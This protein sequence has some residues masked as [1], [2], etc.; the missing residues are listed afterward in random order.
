MIEQGSELLES[1]FWFPNRPGGY[2]S[3]GEGHVVL[4][5]LGSLVPRTTSIPIRRPNELFY[6]AGE[7]ERHAR[8]YLCKYTSC[9]RDNCCKTKTDDGEHDEKANVAYQLLHGEPP[10]QRR[11]PATQ[12]THAGWVGSALDYRQANETIYL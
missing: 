7:Q 8:P 1:G 5:W 10:S 4:V 9:A 3:D 11:L 12:F 2:V 6:C